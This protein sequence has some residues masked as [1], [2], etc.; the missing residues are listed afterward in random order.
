MTPKGCQLRVTY[1]HTHIPPF[2]SQPVTYKH[3]NQKIPNAKVSQGTLLQLSC[4][5]A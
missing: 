5:H 2:S 3:F 1:I 4:L